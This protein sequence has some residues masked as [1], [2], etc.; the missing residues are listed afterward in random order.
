MVSCVCVCVLSQHKYFF[1][2]HYQLTDCYLLIALV[3]AFYH[4]FQR[5]YSN[6]LGHPL[7]LR[8]PG[9]RINQTSS[10]QR[11]TEQNTFQRE[12]FFCLTHNWFGIFPSSWFISWIF[13]ANKNVLL[14]LFII[15][16]LLKQTKNKWIQ[17]GPSQKLPSCILFSLGHILP[18]INAHPDRNSMICCTIQVFIAIH[19]SKFILDYQTIEIF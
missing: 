12:N 18:W 10:E 5:L 8:S 14:S 6:T 13:F 16:H 7:R 17:L 3:S 19:K 11:H 9:E 4:E 2:P 1:T 15:F